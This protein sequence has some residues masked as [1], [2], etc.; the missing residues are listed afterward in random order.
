MK[1]ELKK[2]LRVA[3]IIANALFLIVWSCWVFFWYEVIMSNTPPPGSETNSIRNNVPNAIWT[4]RN[5]NPQAGRGFNECVH[6]SIT[7]STASTRAVKLA[8]R[9]SKRASPEK[10][11]FR[12]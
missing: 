3:I 6:S 4:R 9:L 2:P 11:Y 5:K 1:I 10:T 12:S 8:L 7:Y